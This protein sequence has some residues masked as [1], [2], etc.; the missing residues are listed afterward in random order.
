MNKVIDDFLLLVS[1]FYLTKGW[2]R[3]EV[4]RYPLHPVL[5][6]V[7]EK[8]EPENLLS[9]ALEYPHASIINEGNVAYTR[10][11][12]DGVND[13]QQSTLFGRYIR[14]HFPRLKDHEIRDFSTMCQ[15]SKFEIWGTKEQI[16]RSAIDGPRSCMTFETSNLDHHPY[17][18][19]S[20]EFGW[21]VAVRL[22]EDN[23][24]DGRAL[25]NG[26][27]FVRSYKRG[28]DYS[29]A[30]EALEFWLSEQGYTKEDSWICG[31]KIARIDHGHS[32]VGPY[33]DGDHQ[34]VEDH[35]TYLAISDSGEYE[36]TST[37]GY[38]DEHKE[39]D[40]YC[41]CC[42]DYFSDDE[43]TEIENGETICDNCLDNHFVRGYQRGYNGLVYIYHDNA[44]YCDSDSEY[45]HEDDL[46]YFEVE[47]CEYNEMYY[48]RSELI[49]CNSDGFYYH[50]DYIENNKLFG[51][52]K[53]DDLYFAEDLV[54]FNGEMYY[55]EHL[56]ELENE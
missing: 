17:A 36:A 13:R 38:F 19:Y 44:V 50:S 21:K 16:I 52:D 27:N 33:I 26:T 18:V 39:Q 55:K 43:V 47:R 35:G 22:N 2:Y 12:R 49:L 46:D 23:R 41:E 24:I 32:L 28:T 30:D 1:A 48:H 51:Y 42:N 25:L 56:P 10:S 9:L 6:R 53:E 54:G 5:L 14:K 11:E 8:H 15:C 29:Y 45:Y 4:G 37:S 34:C 31:T 20:P 40:H 3:R 7:L